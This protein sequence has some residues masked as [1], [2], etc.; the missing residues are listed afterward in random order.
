ML[1]SSIVAAVMVL[2]HVA[3]LALP[4]DGTNLTSR[5]DY[6]FRGIQANRQMLHRGAFRAHGVHKSQGSTQASRLEGNVEILCAFDYAAGTFRFDRLEPARLISGDKVR[7]RMGGKLYRTPKETVIWPDGAPAAGVHPPDHPNDGVIKPFDVRAVGLYLGG[8]L[9]AGT[10]FE[11]MWRH[12][13]VQKYE[14]ISEERKGLFQLKYVAKSTVRDSHVTLWIDEGAGFAPVRFETR[15]PDR[16]NPGKWLEPS[17]ISQSSWSSINGVW[18]PKTYRTEVSFP[19]QL[20]RSYD[21]AFEWEAVNQPLNQALFT[22][23]GLELKPGTFFMRREG[24]N[25]IVEGAAGVQNF[26]MFGPEGPLPKESRNW[27]VITGIAAA[28]VV[29]SLGGGLWYVRRLRRPSLQRRR[30]V[31]GASR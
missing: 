26:P 9:D 24:G 14:T 23:E 13:S 21:L 29:L 7:D 10:P 1:R 20:T 18:V 22:K 17:W 30:A 8:S 6:L 31:S 3:L 5:R 2:G 19:G 12:F 16:M 27:M 25:V 11:E 15:H 28:A 4:P